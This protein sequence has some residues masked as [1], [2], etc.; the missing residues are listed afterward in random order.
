MNIFV[1]NVD[2]VAAAQ[3]QCDAH[4]IKMT[5]ETA[6][7]LCSAFPENHAPYRRTHYNHPCSVWTRQTEGNFLWLAEHGLALADEY[8][9]RYGKVHKSREVIDW[10]LQNRPS[11]PSGRTEFVQA[12]PDELKRPD[13]VEAYQIFYVERKR[14][15]AKWNKNRSAPAWWV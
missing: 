2:P 12:M 11:L 14:T 3:E 5:L 8:A 9:F 1:L 13:P 6:Q 15:F 4:V 10:C 7:L